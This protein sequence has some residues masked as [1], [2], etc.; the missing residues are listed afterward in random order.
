MKKFIASALLVTSAIFA[1]STSERIDEVFAYFDF[2]DRELKVDQTAQERLFSSD[3]VMIINGTPVVH[4]RDDLTAHF[5]LLVSQ[6]IELK[7]QIHEKIIAGDKAI[8][9]YDIMIPGKS[10]YKVIAIFKFRDGQVYE[11]NEVVFA[12]DP[13]NEIDYTSK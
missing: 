2:L 6:A 12:V 10:T 4:S 3:F 13:D 7:T 9:R 11:M 5:E 1:N 8:M